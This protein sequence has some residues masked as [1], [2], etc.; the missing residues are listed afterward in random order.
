MTSNVEVRVAVEYFGLIRTAV[1]SSVDTL[2]LPAGCTLRDVL[3]EL[4][5]RY[6]AKFRDALL[7]PRGEPLPNLV[8]T[9]DGR[10]IIDR[11]GMTRPVKGGVIRVLLMP[12]FTGGG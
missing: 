5:L 12:P 6:G 2:S 4:A 1:P 10:R 7:A 8:L 11:E 3:D 9:H